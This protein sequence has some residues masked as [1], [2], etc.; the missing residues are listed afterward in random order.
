M[1]SKTY[2]AKNLKV[3]P[4][5][6]PDEKLDSLMETYNKGLGVTCDF[7]HAKGADGKLDLASDDNPVKEE[8]RRMMR[9]TITINKNYFNYDS[10]VHPAYLTK[11]SCYTCHKGNAYPEE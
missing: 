8:G 9:L 11:V 7:C 10:S 1:N 3:L 5:D 6:I 4:Q 2:K